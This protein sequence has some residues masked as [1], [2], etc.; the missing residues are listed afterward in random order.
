MDRNNP[1]S[2]K[3]RRSVN[4]ASPH[5]LVGMAYE[6]AI[7]ACRRGDSERAR[8]ALQ[9]L[10]DVMRSVGPSDSSDLMRCYDWCLERIGKGEY[11]QAGQTLADL[12]TAWKDAERLFPA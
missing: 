8:K 12:H 6:L 7:L 9:L 4:S 11:A 3:A 1:R 2:A 10:R 5:Q